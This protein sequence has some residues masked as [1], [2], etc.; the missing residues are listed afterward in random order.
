MKRLIA[1]LCLLMMLPAC[2]LAE[3]ALPLG[4]PAPYGPVADAYGEDGLSYDDGTMS[5]RIEFGEAYGVK[6]TYVYVQLTDPSQLRTALAAPY[7]S[8][9]TLTVPQMAEDNHAVLAINGDF[10][11]YH[12]EGVIMRS[13]EMLRYNTS[14]K[15]RGRDMLIINDKGDFEFIIPVTKANYE[16]Y[17]GTPKEIFSFGPALIIDGVVQEYEYRKK[18]SC[19]YPTPAQRMAFC[20]LDT[21]SYLIVY[22]EGPE[23]VE[24]TGLS[25]PQFTELLA[26][27]NV[28]HAYNLD[29]GHSSTIYFNGQRIN[30]P[31]T[32]NR[33][34]G[35]IIYFA[36]LRTDNPQ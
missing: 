19:G 26:G 16:A 36:T 34:V 20:Q 24:N 33:S 5:I 9:K 13:G 12:S 22:T 15:S 2:C 11:S 28:K 18:T 6:V 25:I 31:E 4:G 32:K 7:P 29:G 27:L 23:Q 10:F 14:A 35:D 1:I 3:N 30:S 8:K 21:L 17:T